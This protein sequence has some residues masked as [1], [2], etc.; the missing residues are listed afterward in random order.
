MMAALTTFV[1]V[2]ARG[3]VLRWAPLALLA[4]LLLLAPSVLSEFRINLLGKFL[5]FAILALSLDMIWGYTGM[6][7]LGHGVFFGLGG[8]AFAMFLKLDASGGALPDFMFWNG[9]KEIPFFWVPFQHAWFAIPMVLI[10]PGVLAG[11][12]GYMVFRSRITGVYFAL[13]TQALALVISILFVGQQPYTGGTNGLTDL[14]SVFSF[15][16]YS[17]DTQL[18]LYYITL[19]FLV[20]A[21]LLCYWITS[22][23]FGRLL[24]AV[25]DDENRVRFSGYD[26]AVIKTMVFVLSAGLAGMAGALFAPQVGIISPTMMGIVPSIEIAVWV[27]VGGRGTLIGAVIGAVLV[28]YAKSSLS[29]VFPEFW[30]YFLGALF[31]GAVLLFPGGIV[32]LFRGEGWRWRDLSKGLAVGRA[33]TVLQGIVGGNR[34]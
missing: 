20:G 23:R 31:I 14:K 2:R 25:R 10:V 26:P 21:Y 24:I 18:V 29:E 17:G 32:G 15:S 3:V 28:N 30:T 16:L 1:P 33:R 12:L 11:V 13:I 7:S 5:C 6:L 4:L 27:A 34:R 22:S 9:L 8:Y 19:G